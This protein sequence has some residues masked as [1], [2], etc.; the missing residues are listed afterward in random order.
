MAFLLGEKD[1]DPNSAE[2]QKKSPFQRAE[3][4][5]REAARQKT[6]KKDSGALK[7]IFDLIG[8]NI[9]K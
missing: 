5:R 7:K 6:G 2:Q 9:D 4:E 3:D 1:F 8:G